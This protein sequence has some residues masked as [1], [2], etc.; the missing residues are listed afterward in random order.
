MLALNENDLAAFKMVTRWR[1]ELA[2]ELPN[3][4]GGQGIESNLA[5]CFEQ[6]VRLIRKTEIWWIRE[7]EMSINPDFD[8]VKV[9]DD[10]ITPGSLMVLQLMHDTALGDDQTASAY[11]DFLKKT[12]NLNMPLIFRYGSNCDESRLNDKSRLSGAAQDV[13]L[14]QTI[15]EYDIAF[16]VWSDRNGCAASD[17]M[18]TPGQKARGVLYEIPDDFIRGRRTG[19]QK[20]VAQ[21]EGQRYE[22]KPISVRDRDGN[23]VEEPVTTFLVKPSERRQ[24]LW[25]GAAYVGAYRQRP[26]RSRCPRTVRPTRY[27]CRHRDKQPRGSICGRASATDRRTAARTLLNGSGQENRDRTPWGKSAYEDLQIFLKTP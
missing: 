2:H 20:T 14:A 18:P 13:G 4:V 21:I 1:N 5:E 8:V 22:E 25:T 6:L 12:Q 24:G 23:I 27:R 16:D 3:F 26:P 7:F 11:S 17:L 9:P 19:G 10:D 15:E